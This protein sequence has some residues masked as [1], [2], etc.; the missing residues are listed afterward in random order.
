MS[1]IGYVHAT[2]CQR[3]LDDVLGDVETYAAR[4]RDGCVESET[5]VFKLSGIFIDETVNVYSEDAKDWLDA[6]DSKVRS[7][8]AFGDGRMVSV[9]VLHVV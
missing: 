9:S 6:V 4:T 3:A 8:G 5:A 7:C 2:Y 1:T